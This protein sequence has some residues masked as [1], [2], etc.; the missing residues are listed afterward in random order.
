MTAA[1]PE[2]LGPRRRA[3]G[4]ADPRLAPHRLPTPSTEPPYDDEKQQTPALCAVAAPLGQLE[5][6]LSF[7]P[8]PLR[9][10]LRLVRDDLADA[11]VAAPA[12][13]P[14]PRPAVAQFVQLLLDAVVGARPPTA[15]Q[16]R[17]SSQVYR[18][19]AKLAATRSRE[20]QTG[21][22]DARPTLRSVHVTEPE[23]EVAEACAVVRFGRR[24]RAVALRFEGVGGRWR[25]TAVDL[26]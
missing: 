11:P 18:G 16:G 3:S 6:P 13:L 10:M 1:A 12:D 21:A 23:P 19:V 17:A 4:A 14:D 25:C 15:L 20:H 2:P 24:C 26:G 22:R 7:G 8:P 9:P 5:L